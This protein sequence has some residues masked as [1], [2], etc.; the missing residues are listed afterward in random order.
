M[1]RNSFS[2]CLCLSWDNVFEM[3]IKFVII[4]LS[5]RTQYHL[6]IPKIYPIWRNF[7]CLPISKIFQFIFIKI[8]IYPVFFCTIFDRYLFVIV[9]GFW[10]FGELIF[11]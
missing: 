6:A 7:L 10:D 2:K 9:G 4:A 11:S 8:N 5:I 1:C 3:M